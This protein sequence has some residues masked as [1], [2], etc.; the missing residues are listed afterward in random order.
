V[1]QGQ[2]SQVYGVPEGDPPSWNSIRQVS[3]G[4]KLRKI[5]VLVPVD[6]TKALGACGGLSRVYVAVT[7]AGG[8]LN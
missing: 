8:M 7:F 6:T 3:E 2:L 4:P 5:V 1:G